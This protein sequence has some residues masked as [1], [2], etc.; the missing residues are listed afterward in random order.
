M[1]HPEARGGKKPWR[2]RRRRFQVAA[3][4]SWV[5]RTLRATSFLHTRMK[6]GSTERKLQFQVPKLFGFQPSARAGSRLSS[7][8][9]SRVEIPFSRGLQN[10]DLRKVVQLRHKTRSMTWIFTLSIERVVRV[11]QP[12]LMSWAVHQVSSTAHLIGQP[13]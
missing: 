3:S 4:I 8:A 7:R 2:Q 13:V 11:H 5:H 12:R 10:E 6:E 9:G 1:N